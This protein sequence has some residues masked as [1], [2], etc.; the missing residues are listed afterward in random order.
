MAP[1]DPALV[2]VLRL[3]RELGSDEVGGPLDPDGP[4]GVHF[5]NA[6]HRDHVHIGID[7]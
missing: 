1:D 7:G 3:A 2:R 4:G 6:L 5:A